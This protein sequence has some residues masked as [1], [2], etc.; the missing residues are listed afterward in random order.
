[1]GFWYY[2]GIGVA[3]GLFGVYVLGPLFEWVIEALYDG[4]DEY[5]DRR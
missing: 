2:L 4:T 5:D 3:C 1:M